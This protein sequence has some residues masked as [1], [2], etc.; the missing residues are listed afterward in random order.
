[1]RR[2]FASLAVFTAVMLAAACSG[3]EG[4]PHQLG[5]TSFES[6]PPGGGSRGGAGAVETVGAP[7]PAAAGDAAAPATRT[8]EEADVYKRVGTTLYVLNAYRG[9]QIVDLA[10]PA[11]PRLVARVPVTATPVDLY[12]RGSTAFVVVSDWLAWAAAEDGTRADYGSRLLAIDVSDPAHPGVVADVPLDGQVDQTR[13]VGDVLYVVSRTTSWYGPYASVGLAASGV[14]SGPA[15][16]TVYAASFDVTDPRR[17]SQ[18]ARVELPATGWDTHANV[19]PERI[20]LSFAGWDG[21]AAGPVTRF[22]AVDISDP[23]GAMTLG[24][25][26]SARGTV[27]DRW[28][29]D[30]EAATGLFR[31]VLSS[32]WNAG[33]SVQTWTSPSPDAAAPLS[34]LDIPVAEALTAARF[35]GPRV[36]VVT[37][38]RSDP[39][40][41]VDARDPARPVLVGSLEMPGQLDFIEPRG[42]RLV[43][44]GHTNEAGK[45]FQLAVSLLDVAQLSA[46][47]LLARATFGASFGWV[48]AQADDIRKAFIVLDPPPDGPG[49]VLVPVQGFEPSTYAYAGG[50]QL[51]DLGRDTLTL[52]G[53][54]AHPGAVKR[55][56]PIDAA[57]AR[58][59]ALSDAALQTIDATARD[60]PRELGR[61]DLART[62]STL[63]LVRGKAIELSGDWYRG[64]AELVVTEAADPDAATPLARVPVAAP[65]ARTFQD[66][67]VMWLLAHDWTANRAWL[68]A[69]DFTDPVH[70]VERG[71]LDLAPEDAL[72]GLYPGYWLSGDEAVLVGHALALHRA[73]WLCWGGC[74]ASGPADRITVLD[75][76]DAD[77]PRLSSS[78]DLPGSSW[79]WGLHATGPF[80]WITH[81]EWTPDGDLGR[82]YVDRI[83][84]SDPAHPSLVA[85]VNVPGVFFAAAPDGRT[86]YT[87]ETLWPSASGDAVTW[88]HALALDGAKARLSGS[89]RLDGYP[90]GAVASG[91]HAWVVATRW[92]ED[93][94]ASQVA[95]STPRS[96]LVAVDLR[97]MT[98]SS[99]QAIQDGWAW[100]RTAAGGKLFVQ[101]SFVDEGLLVYGLADPG[102]PVFERFFRTPAWVWDVVVGDGR[103]YLPSGPYGVP[104]IDLAP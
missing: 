74:G 89:V 13:L 96:R 72:G 86:L 46:P 32:G 55:S 99:D 27:Q 24:T 64:A 97:A 18:V 80:L 23:G 104:V 58:L 53:F 83:D 62:V 94:S 42:D 19:T 25:E 91:T 12:V 14:S 9:L 75:L 15:A 48:G 45:P 4:K 40:W 17:P 100:L 41:A 11:A 49:L 95:R 7:A 90:G 33:A 3:G 5:A 84:L 93:A 101:Q 28:A 65:S 102:H 21:T 34:L 39:L 29:M 35:D 51:L 43:A 59:V 77:H 67:D 1:M 38:R 10:D 70:P 98:V 8:V 60:A 88:L 68:Q 6:P 37:A 36:Y 76:A 92:S 87:I 56:F 69:V 82:Y 103:A 47:R 71:R 44:L 81:F 20:T 85:K 78:V 66:G 63:A 2:T 79:S 50:T 16:D 73:S 30:Y 61:L 54:L 57:G 22:R 26:F 52:R 31:A